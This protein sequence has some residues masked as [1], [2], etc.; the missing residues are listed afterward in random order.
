MKR[1]IALILTLLMAL[2]LL[3]AAAYAGETSQDQPGTPVG[4]SAGS[5]QYAILD[6][7]VSRV[8]STASVQLNATEDCTLIVGVF[9][10]NG[11]LAASGIAGVSGTE[12]D[13]TVEVALWGRLPAY[14]L[15][16]AFLVDGNSI[17]L[18]P[19]F[20]SYR[21]ASFMDKTAADFPGQSVVY[22]DEEKNENYAVLASG[23]VELRQGVDFS[24]VT[25]EET[26][27]TVLY[28]LSDAEDSVQALTAGQPV[29][30]YEGD[31]PAYAA[32]VGSVAFSGGDAVITAEADGESSLGTFFDYVTMD[33]TLE[34]LGDEALETEDGV[35]L[36]SAEEAALMAIEPDNVLQS[37]IMFQLN[38]EITTGLSIKGRLEVAVRTHFTFDYAKDDAG[39]E[40]YSQYSQTE[41]V[42][43]LDVELEGKISNQTGGGEFELPFAKVLIVPGV[44]ASISMP[45]TV[46]LNGSVGMKGS[47]RSVGAVSGTD[48]GAPQGAVPGSY[49]DV[50]VDVEAEVNALVAVRAKIAIEPIPKLFVTEVA[51]QCGLEITARDNTTMVDIL[52]GVRHLCP[53]CF[54]G[55]A[56][57]CA[58]WWVKAYGQIGKLKYTLAEI[59]PHEWRQEGIAFYFS[60]SQVPAFGLGICPNRGYLNGF[61]V[62]DAETGGFLTAAKIWLTPRGT[63]N[64]Y[65]GICG[66]E[67]Y[68]AVGTYQLMVNCEGY[69]LYLKD[70]TISGKK[71][72]IIKLIP[73]DKP[74]DWV[75][76]EDPEDPE[77][78]DLPVEPAPSVSYEGTYYGTPYIMY[79]D[80][81]LLLMGDEGGLFSSISYPWYGDEAFKAI[82]RVVY[83]E[84]ITGTGIEAFGSA[85]NL[86][87]V[88]LP[89]TM[90]RI[91]DASFRGS[92][93]TQINF[94]AGIT[95]VGNQ[96]FADCIHLTG[97]VS[98]P[99]VTEI[100]RLAFWKC[101]SIEQASIGQGT[102]GEAAFHGCTSLQ[103]LDLG[104]VTEIGYSA[105]S[106]CGNLSGVSLP[107]ELKVLG[108]C[109][110]EDCVKLTDI[111][112]PG[113]VKT[114][115]RW[116]FRNCT[117]LESAILESGIEEIGE[118]VFA[119]CGSLRHLSIP[120]TVKSIGDSAFNSCAGL[121][122]IIVPDSVTKLG[123]NA[124]YGCTDATRADI[125]G[126]VTEMGLGAFQKCTALTD[127]TVSKAAVLGQSMFENCYALQNISL[128][129]T[130]KEIGSRAFYNC[131]SLTELT[132][133]ASLAS[134]G[135]EAFTGCTSLETLNINSS[136]AGAAPGLFRNF[137]SLTCVNFGDTADRIGVS[138]FEDCDG[139]TELDLPETLKSVGENGFRNCDSLKE[140]TIPAATE[141]LGG[142]AFFD[143]TGLEHVTVL[144]CDTMAQGVFQ[145]CRNL[146]SATLG[147]IS[148][149][150]DSMFDGC[151]SLQEIT[152]PGSAVKVGKCAFLNCT[153][154]K[155]AVL[156]SGVQMLDSY[157]FQDCVNMR[158]ITLPATITAI[159]PSAFWNCTGLT[160]VYFQ[161]TQAQW[162][163][164][165][166]GSDNH[167][168]TDATIHFAD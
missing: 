84:G 113:G 156:E 150:G 15:V 107:D 116:T 155:R 154:L 10:E 165:S 159:A 161:G 21:Y 160:D 28:T 104:E 53:V 128:P 56:V 111:T 78:P 72:H 162:E 83:G 109:A 68:I 87:T 39:I 133:P 130:L 43:E 74:E 5:G 92:G 93:L 44:Y 60:P 1:L 81:T 40:H 152:I 6:L 18:C 117:D 20:Q 8:G 89:S 126:S 42:S 135:S 46:E 17:P 129:D 96:A 86:T 35:T 13:Q 31:E 82:E 24:A 153:S 146:T 127:V 41:V 143:C 157:S 76:P 37:S 140:L 103:E 45:L 7:S 19:V 132:L 151:T 59:T 112:V 51:G 11:Q 63:G 149:V 122:K 88:S 79:S 167:W 114:L 36:L 62:E 123:A 2:T 148:L 47:I 125:G 52:P 66:M 64:S 106:K 168:L 85:P 97:A 54:K 142:W 73:E 100:D 9:A 57:P 80:G 23:V 55:E 61:L 163:Q 25:A 124:F 121:G 70:I 16:R 110:F 33:M 14:F 65:S 69:D 120:D 119:N 145:F 137:D 91:N 30:L 90:E 99:N 50:E 101:A 134:I 22:F 144:G 105:F 12:A 95:F 75:P 67:E 147:D 139:I 158:E 102:I 3:P 38:R 29:L 94:P 118:G 141:S 48:G 136:L 77:N 49:A 115:G 108:G 32:V 26:E 71:E 58:K 138:T 34:E 98:L 166:V 164:I 27:E 4:M 131:E